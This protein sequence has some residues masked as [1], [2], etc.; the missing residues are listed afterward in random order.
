MQFYLANPDTN[1]FIFTTEAQIAIAVFVAIFTVSI[2]LLWKEIFGEVPKQKSFAD[3]RDREE[4]AVPEKKTPEKAEQKTTT[5]D[6][7]AGQAA[8]AAP[9]TET[10]ATDTAA[11]VQPKPPAEWGSALQ[12]SREP[13]LQK[14][15]N[16]WSLLGGGNAWN[17][18]HPLWEALE[19]AMI[20]SDIGPR[21]T[22]QLLEKLRDQYNEEPSEARLR[23]GLQKLMITTLEGVQA[24]GDTDST[25]DITVLI[26]V[27]GSGKT[28][29]TGKLAYKAKQAGKSVIVGAGDT[30]RAAAVEQLKTWA[31]RIQVECIE[32]AQGA[33]PAAVAFD[34]VQA[35]LSRSI[36]KII[37]DTAGRLHT[38]DSL[39]EELKKVGRVIEKKAGKHKVYLVLD[40]T[41]GQNAIIQAKEFMQ[42]MPITGVILTK[43]DG[44]AKGGAAFSVVAELGIPIVY[45]GLGESADDLREFSAREFVENLLPT[46]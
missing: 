21:M 6:K 16:A 41:L 10:A 43:L 33:N 9:S 34:T 24:P 23:E 29:T 19:E 25:P 28:T 18:A 42:V 36:D 38:K 7:P 4:P 40:A 15:K 12:K 8:T 44:S 27:N 17:D 35:G 5:T 46:A 31:E 39:M 13:L 22:V 26:G 3:Y 30:F 11:I 32:P 14:L 37:I 20:T 1:T 45:V 2:L